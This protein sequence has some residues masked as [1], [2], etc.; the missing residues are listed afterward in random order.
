[1]TTRKWVVLS[2]PDHRSLFVIQPAAP[3][4]DID[5]RTFRMRSK[6]SASAVAQM[7]NTAEQHAQI[8]ELARR[9][10]TAVR[11]VNG[12]MKAERALFEAL[13]KLDT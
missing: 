1:M 12:I 5:D 8:V 13:D 10:Q 4:P 3:E 6:R 2:H 9:F 11:D 7:L